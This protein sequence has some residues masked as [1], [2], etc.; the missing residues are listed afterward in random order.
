MYVFA[1]GFAPAEK[2]SMA[3]AETPR[4]I[5]NP[6]APDIFITGC[7]GIAC[8]AGTIA[9]T[10]ENARCDHSHPTPVMER[11][12]V[13]RLALTV[14]AAQ[15][16]VTTLNSFLEQQGMSPSKAMAGGAMFQ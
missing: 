1:K 10:V 4:L 6:F 7:S 8:I 5:D 11:M 14:P 12:V 15:M 2:A 3:A 16:L 9:V 13:G